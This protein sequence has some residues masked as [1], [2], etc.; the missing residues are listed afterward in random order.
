MDA[1]GVSKLANIDSYVFS[2]RV[3]RHGGGLKRTTIASALMRADL[4]ASV[5]QG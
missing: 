1:A 5:H 4:V 3:R 2:A